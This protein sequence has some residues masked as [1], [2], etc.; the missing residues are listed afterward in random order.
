[1]S[2]REGKAD[3]DPD[4]NTIFISGIIPKIHPDSELLFFTFDY[5]GFGGLLRDYAI[6]TLNLNP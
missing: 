1:M 4:T 5:N 2:V 3:I 6:P